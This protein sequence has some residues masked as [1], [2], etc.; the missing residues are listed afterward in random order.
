MRVPSVLFV[1][2]V[3]LSQ[4]LVAGITIRASTGPSKYAVRGL[5]RNQAY[6][7]LM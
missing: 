3:L 4:Q 5:L 7:E 1:A 2:A 6:K